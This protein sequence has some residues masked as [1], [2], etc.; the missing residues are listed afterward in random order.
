MWTRPAGVGAYSILLP[1]GCYVNMKNN[2]HVWEEEYEFRMYEHEKHRFHQRLMLSAIALDL[3]F[4]SDCDVS[5]ISHSD[6]TQWH[7]VPPPRV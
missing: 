1:L 7:Q 5:A 2:F 4:S 3:S 6:T